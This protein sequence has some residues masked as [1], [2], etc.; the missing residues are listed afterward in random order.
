MLYKYE[1]TTLEGEKKSGSIEAANVEI[2]V[3]SLQRRNLIIVSIHPA[4]KSGHFWE[5]NLKL[6]ERVKMRDVVILSRQLS[7]LFEA[8][9]PVLDSFKLLAAETENSLLRAKLSKVLEDIQGGS[10]LSSAMAKH[11]DVFSKFYV[12]MI[13]SGVRK[14]GRSFFVSGGLP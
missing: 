10:S 9:V 5:K 2:A 8:K 12:S 4:G 11:P 3:S 1:A 13:M 14:A 6:F 7:T